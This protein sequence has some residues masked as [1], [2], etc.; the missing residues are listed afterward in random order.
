[1]TVYNS[2]NLGKEIIMRTLLSLLIGIML[3]SNSA[4]AATIGDINNDEKVG[5][6]EAI[7]ALEVV[8]GFKTETS[9]PT[10]DLV[11]TW[12]VESPMKC[13]TYENYLLPEQ[14]P[15]YVT[16]TGAFLT[17]TTQTEEVF[18]GYSRGPDPDLEEPPTYL[19]GI[20]QGNRITIQMATDDVWHRINVVLVLTDGQQK[21]VGMF[22]QFENQ[23]TASNPG[24]LSCSFEAVKQ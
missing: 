15:Q 20:A 24:I 23:A 7:Y 17:I 14:S 2:F 5:L 4:T 13:F 12:V 18:A 8:A 21:L 11:G 22:E 16:S 1:V 3:L 6:P 19:T 10:P 9:V